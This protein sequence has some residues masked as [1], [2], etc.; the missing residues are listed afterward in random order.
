MVAEGATGGA[1]ISSFL[2]RFALETITAQKGSLLWQDIAEA[3]H[4]NDAGAIP[5]RSA[6][7]IAGE[8]GRGAA[9][10]DVIHQAMAKFTA[11]VGEF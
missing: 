7:G 8:G 11:R 4:E 3:G 5:E 6:I 2:L 9:P 10:F 1:T